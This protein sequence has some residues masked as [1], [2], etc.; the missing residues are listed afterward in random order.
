MAPG[1]P[2]RH[3]GAD[4][5]R[6]DRRRDHRCAARHHRATAV[7]RPG[8]RVEP[9]R[10]ASPL[11][12]A[13]RDPPDPAARP[14][15]PAGTDPVGPAPDGR[16]RPPRSPAVESRAA[17][18]AAPG[19]E[20]GTR[21]LRPRS[22]RAPLSAAREEDPGLDPLARAGA[23]WERARAKTHYLEDREVLVRVR[24]LFT[25][26]RGQVLVATTAAL[27][28]SGGIAYATGSG[29][30]DVITAG[31]LNNVG[32]IR[33]IE[34]GKSGLKGHCSNIETQV[35][36][37]Q[38]GVPGEQGPKGDK[39]DPGAAGAKGDKG[40]PGAPGAKG[41]TGAMG[42]KGDP[43]EPG[44]PGAK[45]D[46]GDTGATGA[47]GDQEAAG[48]PGAK[49]DKGDTGAPGAPG[50]KG[51]KGDTGAPGAKGDTGAPGAAG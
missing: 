49:G 29:G 15:A 40:D 9:G 30:S 26:R 43:G 21:R 38:K 37:N 50:G 44:A 8:S 19:R 27:A 47:K 22:R 11:L 34:P 17:R 4:G 45:G 6:D 2:L 36:W 23:L 3:A 10:E 24:A 32:T 5:L 7:L 41:D 12:Q 1:E 16:P 25:T 14:P 20:A 42:A 13:D 48:A 28:V 39:G 18:A 35:T 46:K 51:D 31:E 33:L